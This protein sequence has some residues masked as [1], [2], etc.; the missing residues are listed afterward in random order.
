[1][2][3]RLLCVTVIGCFLSFLASSTLARELDRTA[4]PAQLMVRGEAV[5][6]VPADQLHVTIGVVTSAA[7]AELALEQNSKQMQTVEQALLDAGLLKDELHTSRF[8]IQPQWH[9]GEQKLPSPDR[10]ARIVGYTVTNRFQVKTAK[11]ER[12]G[13]IIELSTRAGANLVDAIYFDLADPRQ[14]RTRA[15]DE[16]YAHARA[17]AEAAAAASGVK[18]GPILSLQLDDASVAPVRVAGAFRAESAMVAAGAAPVI[19]PADVTVRATVSV[20]FEIS[21]N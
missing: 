4:T 16:A 7:T 1:M 17:D 8:Q 6:T 14:Y 3:K 12:A 11:L 19:N 10:Q 18:L 13:K 9:A 15:I 20:I 21:G 2:G 5:F